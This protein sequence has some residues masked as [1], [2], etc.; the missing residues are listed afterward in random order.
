VGENPVAGVADVLKSLVM[1]LSIP[2]SAEAEAKL[3]E[4]AALAGV[5]VE[6]YAASLVERMVKAP[7]SLKEI[8]GPILK[9]LPRAG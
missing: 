2:I 9:R 1:V 6:T 4:K 3:K 7:L 8:S 5:D